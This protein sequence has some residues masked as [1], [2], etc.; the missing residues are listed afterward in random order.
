VAAVIDAVIDQSEADEGDQARLLVKLMLDRWV[1]VVMFISP[2]PVTFESFRLAVEDDTILLGCRYG[3]H[4]TR[5]IARLA[6]PAQ[7]VQVRRF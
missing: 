6:S 4:L 1:G 3:S 5:N 2:Q 7:R